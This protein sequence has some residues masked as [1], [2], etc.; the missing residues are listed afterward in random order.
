MTKTSKIWK[1][2][3]NL[4]RKRR[5]SNKLK[6]ISTFPNHKSSNYSR[7]ALLTK[8]NRRKLKRSMTVHQRMIALCNCS[9]KFRQLRKLEHKLRFKLKPL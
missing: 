2:R 9:H 7:L 5:L 4:Q 1:M 3:E 6:M 8:K